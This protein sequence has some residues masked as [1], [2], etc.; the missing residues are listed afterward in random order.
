[1][2]T[3]IIFVLCTFLATGC[4]NTFISKKADTGDKRMQ[5]CINDNKPKRDSKGV[6]VYE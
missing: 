6:V 5:K 2:K 3:I 4:D 1:V